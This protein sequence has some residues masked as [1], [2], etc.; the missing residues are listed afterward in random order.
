[1]RNF[2]LLSSVL[3]DDVGRD[4]VCT[5]LQ[6]Y[7]GIDLYEAE[8]SLLTISGQ[9]LVKAHCGICVDNCDLLEEIVCGLVECATFDEDVELFRHDKR[10]HFGSLS[11]SHVRF[12]QVI[13]E[14]VR[15]DGA[16]T[17]IRVTAK[18]VRVVLLTFC[19]DKGATLLVDGH[20][21]YTSNPQDG[22]S[23]I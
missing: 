11:G 8:S 3:F 17:R 19:F 9:L 6:Q 22:V 16:H 23:Q 13:A 5:I 2:Q 20:C 7:L 10:M 18:P 21:N 14:D 12:E 1:M 4:R 15:E